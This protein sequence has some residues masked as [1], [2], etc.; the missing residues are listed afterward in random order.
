MVA[1]QRQDAGVPDGAVA[2]E[3]RVRGAAAEID[4]QDPELFLFVGHDGLGRGEGL[5]HDVL[6]LEP[7]AVD[8]ADDISHGGRG[9]RHQVH[10]DLEP[11][12]RHPQ[13]LL[14]AVLVVHDIGLRQRVDDL[15]ILRQV[16]RPGGVQRPLDVGGADLAMLARHGDH[17]PAVGAANVPAGHAGDHAR[18]LDAGHLLGVAH[19]LLDALNRRVNVDHHAFAKSP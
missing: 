12:P 3:R 8:A 6:H 9:A 10:L 4:E 1:A 13:R 16:D 18:D 5:E 17:A 11:H 14:D 7:R 19:G 2:E 15:A